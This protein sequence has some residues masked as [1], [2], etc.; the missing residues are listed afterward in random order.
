MSAMS[1]V[2]PCDTLSN[3]TTST[4]RAQSQDARS[5]FSCSYTRFRTAQSI[6]NM[7]T[8]L[9]TRETAKPV[10]SFIFEYFGRRGEHDLTLSD[11]LKNVVKK[12]KATSAPV[13]GVA[14]LCYHAAREWQ[15][16]YDTTR[17]LQ[18]FTKTRQLSR[19]IHCDTQH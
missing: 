1:L 3:P 4:L 8:R 5:A 14:P 13:F 9:N 16:R 17:S 11:K 2:C 19:H 7:Y 15:T 10:I 18:A 12:E 6:R